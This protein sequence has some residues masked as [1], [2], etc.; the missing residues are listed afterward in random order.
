MMN[1]KQTKYMRRI[2]PFLINPVD[3]V[4]LVFSF[5]DSINESTKPIKL[6][7]IGNNKSVDAIFRTT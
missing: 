4:S 5:T 3:S 2:K 6:R 7:G 1:I